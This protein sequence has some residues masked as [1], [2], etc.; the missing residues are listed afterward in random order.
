MADAS[1]NEEQ[2]ELA[3]VTKSRMVR[4]LYYDPKKS[5][6]C[7]LTTHGRLRIHDGVSRD[8]VTLI[9]EHEHPGHAYQMVR[10]ELGASISP[11]SLSSFLSSRKAK[12]AILSALT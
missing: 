7:V 4:G 10:H 6:L 11:F 5:R 9:A 8:T 3:I 12:R 2:P 1:S